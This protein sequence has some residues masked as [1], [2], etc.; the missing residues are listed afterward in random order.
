MFNPH[1]Y[2]ITPFQVG[3]ELRY[4]IE[5]RESFFFNTWTPVW[6]SLNV[7]IALDTLKCMRDHGNVV[8]IPTPYQVM[9]FKQIEQIQKQ[10]V[11]V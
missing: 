9:I 3:D 5:R 7:D 10:Y 4:T 8:K 11:A 6:Y 2:R 1:K